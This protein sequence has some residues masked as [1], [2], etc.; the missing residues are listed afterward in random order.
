V[1]DLAYGPDGILYA[2]G[3]FTQIG[4]LTTVN[5]A[6]AWN[7]ASWYHLDSELFGSP[8]LCVALGPADPMIPTHYDIWIGASGSAATAIAGLTTVTNDGTA[9]AWP[10]IRFKRTGGTTAKIVSIRNVR[11][12]SCWCLT[13]VCWTARR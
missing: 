4:A 3:Q 7:G 6:A 2:V 1:F 11:T 10:T 8:A 9:R 12:G 5:L 13:M